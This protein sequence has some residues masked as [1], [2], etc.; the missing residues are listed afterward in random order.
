MPIKES[1]NN[2]KIAFFGSSDFSEIVLSELE[3]LELIPDIFVSTEDTQKGRGL[4]M[5]KTPVKIWAETKDKK[6]LQPKNLQEIKD[7][8]RDFNLF[9][10]ASY[11]KIIPKS[12]LE[13]PK[14]GTLNIHPSLLPEYRGASPLQSAILDGKDKT[15]VSI[16]LVDDKMDHGPV[17]TQEEIG[18]ESWKPSLPEL[19]EKL[20][21]IGA[22]L[23]IKILPLWIENKIKPIDQNHDQATFTKKINKEDGFIKSTTILFPNK[24]P[25]DAIVAERKIRA[26]NPNP[27]T[28]T[29]FDIK[30]KK[31]RVKITKARPDNEKILVIEKV[32]PEG[33]KEMTWQDF[34]RGYNPMGTE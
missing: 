32:I 30:N 33:K 5:E 9:I 7:I 18:I 4:K 15:G 14:Y 8:L 19:K 34:L 13:I 24:N 20:A 11:G 23:I 21:K 29:F 17:F 16:M 31:V 1:S 22:K 3:R 26:L 6:V 27:G 10:V 2:L 12:I 25:G 28:F